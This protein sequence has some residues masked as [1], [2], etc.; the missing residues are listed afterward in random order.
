MRASQAIV[1]VAALRCRH[2]QPRDGEL[3]KMAAR[4]L[5]RDMRHVGELA[6]RE[7][8]TVH[9]RTQDVGARRIADQRP[10]HSHVQ[11][12]AHGEDYKAPPR[13]A[14]GPMLRPRP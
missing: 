13:H 10:H 6:G 8:A 1:T 11:H 2:D 5:R 14:H 7:G 9:Q 4:G 12:F 3:A